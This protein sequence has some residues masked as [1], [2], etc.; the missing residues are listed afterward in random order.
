[1]LVPSGMVISPN[2]LGVR[3]HS[4]SSEPYFYNTAYALVDWCSTLP[5]D[6]YGAVSLEKK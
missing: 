4:T 5:I 3:L 2:N 6:E 1:M